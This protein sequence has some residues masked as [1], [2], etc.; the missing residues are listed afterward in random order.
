MEEEGS[1]TTFKTNGIDEENEDVI[2][3]EHLTYNNV[4]IKPCYS[5][6]ESRSNCDTS[7]KLT[8]NKTIDCPVVASPMDTICEEDMAFELWKLGGFGFIHRFDEISVQ[9]RR[10]EVTDELIRDHLREL[11]KP[12]REITEQEAEVLSRPVEIGAA[13]GATGNYLERAKNLIDAGATVILI[14]VANGDHSFVRKALTELNMKWPDVPFVAGNVATASGTRNLIEWGASAVRVGI[15]GG[16]MC[17]T[18]LRTGVGVPQLSAVLASCEARDQVDKEVPIIS[19]GGIK[20]PGDLAKAIAAGADTG[21]MG[22]VLSGTK[23]TPGPML[24][25]GTFPDERLYKRYMGSASFENKK[26]RGEET[27]NVEGNSKTVDYKGKVKRVFRG[28]KEGLQSSMS[29]VGAETISDFKDNSTLIRVT[30]AGHVEGTPHGLD[31]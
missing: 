22:S 12:G 30:N 2:F 20:N 9:S 3:E 7:T 4:Q 23:E 16:S 1:L 24:R 27:K 25:K 19:D 5:S 31:D 11:E 18:R 13:I 6:V 8:K 21:M 14:D 28:L 29:Y 26:K 17:S 10:I 15:G